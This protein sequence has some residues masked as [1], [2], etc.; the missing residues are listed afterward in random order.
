MKAQET[1]ELSI[2]EYFK[3]SQF[4]DDQEEIIP[5][6]YDEE[7]MTQI[8]N[9]ETGQRSNRQSQDVVEISYKSSED[10]IGS[11]S[12]QVVEIEDWLSESEFCCEAQKV[13]HEKAKAQDEGPEFKEGEE[14]DEDDEEEK[15][16]KLEEAKYEDEYEETEDEEEKEVKEEEKE[17]KEEEEK[18]KDMIIRKMCLQSSE[19]PLTNVI[20]HKSHLKCPDDTTAS[21]NS[22]IQKPINYPNRQSKKP[23]TLNENKKRSLAELCAA[24]TPVMRYR[25]GLSKRNNVESLHKFI[26]K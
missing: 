16:E 8:S 22:Y 23:S 15:Q 21:E 5:S 6:T 2:N 18:E 1:D 14:A 11:D 9:Q 4:D 17:N 25:V 24:S 26:K 19:K 13:D 20:E 12:E 10:G 3:F 7:S